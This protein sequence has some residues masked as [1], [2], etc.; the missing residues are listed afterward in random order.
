MNQVKVRVQNFRIVEDASILIK[1]ITGLVGESN[2]GKTSIYSAIKTALYNIAG[3]DYVRSGTRASAVGIQFED[4]GKPPVQIIF[5]KEGSS[6]YLFNGKKYEKVGRTVPEDIEGFINMSQVELGDDTKINLN[7]MDQLSEPLL[8][9]FS[10]TKLYNLTIKSFDGEK[11]NEAI[12]LAKKDIDLFSDQINKMNVEHEVKK[13]DLHEVNVKLE[14]FSELQYVKENYLKYSQAKKIVLWIEGAQ[15]RL[16]DITRQLQVGKKVINDTQII[17]KISELAEQA[18][19]AQNTVLKIDDFINDRNKL[20]NSL[21]YSEE[22]MQKFKVIEPIE[23]ELSAY[24]ANVKNYSRI[25]D[26]IGRREYLKNLLGKEQD[27]KY[28]EFDTLEPDYQVILISIEDL[29]LMDEWES[30]LEKINQS[31]HSCESF[32]EAYNDEEALVKQAMER[33]ECPVCGSKTE[34][35]TEEMNQE[36]YKKIEAIKAKRSQKEGEK[37]ILT[38]QLNS[39]TVEIKDA[40]YSPDTLEQDRA[41]IEKSITEFEAKAEPVVNKL[42]QELGL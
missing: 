21:K 40:G 42:Y 7:F 30:K 13:K 5:K 28:K 36:F 9:K 29:K 38:N 12:K 20:T 2:H 3:T 34:E 14:Q 37:E 6:M 35:N 39:L 24:E 10:D 25:V 11:V 4:E 22:F 1:G 18:K 19:K 16:G 31:L 23:L 26:F 8:K 41:S 27:A 32:I 17:I 15:A 33:H